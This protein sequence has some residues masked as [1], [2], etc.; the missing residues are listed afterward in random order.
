LLKVYPEA[1]VVAD[2][3]G[4]LPLHVACQ[5]GSSVPVVRMLIRAAPKSINAKT[6]RGST[7]LMCAKKV[8]ARDM[9]E[10][11]VGILERSAE[12]T[13]TREMQVAAGQHYK[14]DDSA[15]SS[16]TADTSSLHSNESR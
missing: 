11:L 1:A 8:K 6:K 13:S 15:L 10:E 14:S 2:I 4:F 7:A 16:F 9:Q 3:N 12:E 5:F